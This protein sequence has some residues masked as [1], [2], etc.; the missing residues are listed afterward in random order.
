VGFSH[1]IYSCSSGSTLLF[2]CYSD[3][4]YSSFTNV[5]TKRTS[6]IVHEHGELKLH[7]THHLS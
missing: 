7:S 4:T 6:L 3:W 1:Y 5:L 2:R